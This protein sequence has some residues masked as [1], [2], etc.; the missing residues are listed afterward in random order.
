[1]SESIV[2]SHRIL[3]AVR[4]VDK[5]DVHEFLKQLKGAL[6]DGLLATALGWWQILH[7]PLQILSE[8]RNSVGFERWCIQQGVAR[9]V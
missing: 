9:R 3:F 5:V 2:V 6:S 8:M 7:G 1:M 4:V